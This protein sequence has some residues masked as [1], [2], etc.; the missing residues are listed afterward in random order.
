MSEPIK[1]AL[2]AEEWEP[3]V[4]RRR[5]FGIPEIIHR[6]AAIA[7]Y[8]QPFGFTREDV[9]L[10]RDV[11]AVNDSDMYALSDEYLARYRDLADRIEA[12][13]PPE[14]E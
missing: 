9:K 11:E 3:I 6:N 1:P 8:G 4:Q 10:V 2:T 5:D 13:L 7:L 14:K 12:L